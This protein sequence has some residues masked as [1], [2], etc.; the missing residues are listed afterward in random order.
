MKKN[1][2]N[3]PPSCPILSVKNLSKTFYSSSFFSQQKSSCKAV[4]NIS[5]NLHKGE[6]LG[7]VGAN[8]A[9]K[10][11]TLHLLLGTLK[12]TGGQIEYFGKNF[13]AH[14]SEILQKVGFASSSVQLPA[15]LSV[16]QNLDI[17]ARLYGFAT[18]ARKAKIEKMLR[19]FDVWHLREAQTGRLSSGQA[20]RVILAK[21]FLNDPEIVYLDEITAGFDPMVAQEAETFF[22]NQKNEFGT[23]IVLASHNMDEVAR[24]CDRIA[25]IKDGQIIA[26][27]STKELAQSLLRLHLTLDAE[28]HDKLDALL[29]FLQINH[30]SHFE[31]I[32]ITIE[33]E[34]IAPLL[35]KIAHE[36]I[37]YSS[38]LL[39]KPTFEDQFLRLAGK[40]QQL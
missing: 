21:A 27:Y 10:T 34:N 16:M 23:S 25:I 40:V 11:T 32:I 38:I 28:N 35:T 17:H 18:E 36:K 30:K 13:Y 7:L 24:I 6:I 37:Q 31:K 39:E 5:F 2:N 8:G 9:G 20:C 4:N 14:R 15:V 3:P 26:D 22:L 19:A 29:A 33:E 12:P 1:N